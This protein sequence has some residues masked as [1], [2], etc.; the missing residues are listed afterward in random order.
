MPHCGGANSCNCVVTG[1]GVSGSGTLSDPYVITSVPEGGGG[2]GGGVTDHGA[3]TG[4]GD[5]DHPQY[6][7]ADG[8]R[9][10]F[11]TVAQG[12]KADTAVQPAR[13]ITAGTGLTGGGDLSANRTLAVAYGTTST[14]AT[15]GNDSRVTGAIQASITDA[16]G[17]IIAATAADT[18]AR[19]AVGSAGDSLTPDS[20]A[21]TGVAWAIPLLKVA[22]TASTTIA[23]VLADHGKYQRLTAATA[24]TITLP[25]DATQAFPIGSYLL[26]KATAAGLATF[27]AG[28]SATLEDAT[29]SAVMRAEGSLVQATKVAANTWTLDG[30]LA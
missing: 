17:D 11:A 3:L 24:V 9:G 12:V 16:K 10:S 26:Y 25:S 28:S 13:T 30:D 15:V 14:T 18:V 8:S 6:A 20:S 2:G 1:D 7:L 29:P 4:L 27:V 5:D 19:V 22:S 23:P 21:G